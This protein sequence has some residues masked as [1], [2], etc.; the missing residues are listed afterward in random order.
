VK[1]ACAWTWTLPLLLAAIGCAGTETGNPSFDGSVGYDAYSS[2][3]S[4][5]ALPAGLERPMTRVAL[6]NAWLV[7]GDVELLP[8]G[9]CGE[10]GDVEP[11]VPGLGPG[12]HA[13]GQAPATHSEMSSGLYCGARLPFVSGS[14]SL[15][16]AAPSSVRDHAI[17]LEGTLADG[18]K[19]E[20][21][22]TLSTRVAVQASGAGFALDSLH[23][24]VV[25]GFDVA[26]WLAE[27]EW[28]SAPDDHN[29]MID[30]DHNPE[31]LRAFESRLASGVSLFRDDDEDG[32]LDADPVLLAAPT[33]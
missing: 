18:R 23:R 9:H 27:L 7:L 31:L 25:F 14:E 17:V 13:G 21:Q 32:V 11:H 3:P 29:V 20:L 22:S 4:V 19:F 24:G 15:P 8:A 6:D 33:P 16:A 5:V 26:K 2:S 10:S 12:D 28:S 1:G 30:A